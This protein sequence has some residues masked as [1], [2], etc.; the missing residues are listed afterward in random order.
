MP[1]HHPMSRRRLLAG[2][3][4]A[5]LAGAGSRLRAEDLLPK[6]IT[7][8]TVISVKKGLD[9]LAKVQAPDGSWQTRTSAAPLRDARCV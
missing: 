6:H 2:L 4:A 8:E 9:Y 3:S 5:V 1:A 7:K